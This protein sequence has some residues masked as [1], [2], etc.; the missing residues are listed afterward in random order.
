MLAELVEELELELSCI[1][2]G[3]GKGA[4]A[5]GEEDDRIQDG[6]VHGGGLG[7]AG[8]RRT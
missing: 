4:G 5:E 6:E 2:G 1:T 8:R 7:R 3:S